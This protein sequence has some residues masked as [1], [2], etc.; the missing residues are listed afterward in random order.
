MSRMKTKEGHDEGVL[1]DI[2]GIHGR[3]AGR[4]V[5]GVSVIRPGLLG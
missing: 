4:G 1:E 5:V 2:F 3:F